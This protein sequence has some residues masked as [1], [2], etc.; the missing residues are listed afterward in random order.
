MKKAIL[1]LF[2]F[3]SAY[4]VHGQRPTPPTQEWCKWAFQ[5]LP[6]HR[7]ISE[8]D[9]KAFSVDFYTLLKVAFTIDEWEVEKYPGEIGY[10]EFLAYWYAGN[11]DSPLA[12][13]GHTIRYKVG[14]VQDGKTS[15]EITIQIPDRSPYKPVNLRFT[16]YLVYENESWRIDD[17]FDWNDGMNGSMRKALRGYIRWYANQIQEKQ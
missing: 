5:Q 16:M 3:L 10:G 6:D 7:N 4:V 17:W 2:C 15:V 8:V 14:T 1:F 13:W 12:D 9:P 11:G